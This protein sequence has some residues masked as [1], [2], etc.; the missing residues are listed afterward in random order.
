MT[1][2]LWQVAAGIAGAV[3]VGFVV[4]RIAALP[5][6]RGRR[7]AAQLVAVGRPSIRNDFPASVKREILN[8]P[9]LGWRRQCR[10]CWVRRAEEADHL[11]SSAK[12]GSN[13]S[14]NGAPLCDGC[15]GEKSA[16]HELWAIARWVT[17]WFGWRFPIPTP[18]ILTVA[19]AAAVILTRLYAT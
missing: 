8:G 15:N 3:W 6:R 10:K 9:L 4:A 17:P 5:V 11:I 1:P 12:G 18:A 14:D 13:K 7:A 16:R 19:A 2:A